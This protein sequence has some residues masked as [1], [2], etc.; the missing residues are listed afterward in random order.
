M[1]SSEVAKNK[2]V[3]QLRPM[4]WM[5]LCLVPL[6]ALTPAAAHTP[7]SLPQNLE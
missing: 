6:Q 5:R 3:Q 1:W 4:F 7:L 2:G